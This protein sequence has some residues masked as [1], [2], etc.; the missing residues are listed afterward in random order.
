MHFSCLPTAHRCDEN[1]YIVVQFLD[2]HVEHL[3]GPRQVF[4][5]R[6]KHERVHVEA[7]RRY[8][9]TE[10]QCIDVVY[11]TG[12][13][14]RML[15]PT[16]ITFDP[17]L[18]QSC[19]VRELQR[20]VASQ[21]EY[22]VV[23]FKDGR[24]EHVRGPYELCFHPMEHESIRMVEALKLAANEAI[25]VYRRQPSALAAEGGPNLLAKVQALGAGA[26]DAPNDLAIKPLPPVVRGDASSA[27]Q[28]KKVAAAAAAAAAASCGE[29][30]PPLLTT[31]VVGQE[32]AMFV[33]R[34][35]VFGPAV[36]IPDS[37][38]WLHEFSWHGSMKADGK[39]SKTGFAGDV[40]VPHALKFSVLRC[41]PDSMYLS[42]RDVRTVD[43]ANLT[44]H[45]M[46]FYELKSIE[47]M[48]DSTND[49]IGDLV[50]AASADVM[51]FGSRLTY[52]AFLS[53][54]N[55]L[56]KVEN[57]PILA[58]RM[59]QTGTSLLK[60]VYRGYNAGAQLQ[61]MHDQAISR[62][63]KLRLEGD[64]ARE[65][66]QR[67]ATELRCRQE[68]SEQEQALEAGTARH[69]LEVL[70]LQKE[71]ER[72]LAD[73]SHAQEMRY[74]QEQHEME[75]AFE[76]KRH[77][78]ALRQEKEQAELH[79]RRVHDDRESELKKYEAL[80]AMGVDLTALLT[81]QAAIKP[82][83]VLKIDTSGIGQGTV[84]P[85]V[86]LELPRSR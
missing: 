12:R 83:Q 50:N 17:L 86:H 14:M 36:F 30:S 64:A 2:G 23:Q 22:L 72:R 79:M 54:T 60:V 41:M 84:P 19:N 75:S 28:P 68:R 85:A 44:V 55:E 77:D 71:Q 1:S 69:K 24:K 20:H 26:L 39:G 73:E 25:V 15:G 59:A 70:S 53:Q 37:F 6:W 13:F 31:E 33:E 5:D 66:Q 58:S 40:K 61:D 34:R 3:Q 46:L 27:G 67:K 65:E 8:V 10:R 80:K 43:D 81:A 7:H 82:D 49:L 51:T 57:F 45:L 47:T 78:E 76:R 11:L 52:E 56:S 63:T 35:V 74:A 9:A 29:P 4:F 18:H 48:L 16:N 62:R 38:E 21:A 42:V 32:G